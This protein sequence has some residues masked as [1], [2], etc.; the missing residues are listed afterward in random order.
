[1]VQ[2][3]TFVNRGS[4]AK[5]SAT[6]ALSCFNCGEP[7]RRTSGRLRFSYCSECP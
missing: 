3:S 5:S 4:L 6:D 2:N 1:L 7:I